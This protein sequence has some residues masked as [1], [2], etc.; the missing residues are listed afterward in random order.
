ML[1]IFHLTSFNGTI[2]TTEAFHEPHQKQAKESHQG[3]GEA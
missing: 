2:T 1:F 3:D